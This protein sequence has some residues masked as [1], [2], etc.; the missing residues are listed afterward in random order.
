V[1]GLYAIVSWGADVG[2]DD[3]GHVASGVLGKGDG[4]EAGE[5]TQTDWTLVTVVIA[6]LIYNVATLFAPKDRCSVPPEQA[7]LEAVK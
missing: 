7:K 2:G 6:I 4:Q 5:M 3:A 1:A